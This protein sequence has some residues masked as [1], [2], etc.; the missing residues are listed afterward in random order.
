[1][2]KGRWSGAGWALL[3]TRAA[4]RAGDPGA[5]LHALARGA[6]TAVGLRLRGQHILLLLEPALAGSLL[7]E[8][9]AQST[10]GPG[11]QLT[12]PL[13]G[14][15]LLT[16]EGGTHHR[17]RRLIAPAF[18]P[19]RLADYTAGFSERTNAFLSRWSDGQVVDM[20]REMG[21]LTLDIVGH[22][23]L[24]VDLTGA[25]GLRIRNGLESALAGFDESGAG[26]AMGGLRGGGRRR[27]APPAGTAPDTAP[28]HDLIEEIIAVRR[29]QRSDDPVV[30]DRGDVISALLSASEQPDG[31]TAAEVHDNV[32]TLL[33]AGRYPAIEQRL[34]DEVDSHDGAAPTFATLALWPYTRAVITESMRLYPPAWLL[35]RTLQAP[36]QFDAWRAPAGTI[37][38]VSP[39]LLHHDARWFPEPDRFDPERWLDERRGAVP[40]HA[41]LPFGTGP[42]ACI[43]EQ[44]AWAEATTAL[45]VIAA[46]WSAA[47]ADSDHQ[48]IPQ[49]RVTMRPGNGLPMRIH[50]RA[51]R[52]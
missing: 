6:Q 47:A 19:R 35:G 42:R 27:Q 5:V 2:R 43:G 52:G 37:V 26:L 7:I 13:L 15:G 1:V 4:R 44:F 14:D 24:G 28:V 23:L 29:A 11:V 39:L 46:G 16:S 32:V 30:G 49:Y 8:H 25:D 18:S 3:R 36:V 9:A 34:H 38:A 20:H 45:A 41:Y 51:L 40:R 10:K 12:R 17:A 48:V 22:T 33:M 50:A 31:L 21:Q